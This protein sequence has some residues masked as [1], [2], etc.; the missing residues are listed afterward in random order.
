MTWR[1]GEA[2]RRAG[3]TPHA[4]RHYEALG[5]LRPRRSPSGQR[6]Y[7]EEDLKRVGFV[8]RAAALGFSLGEIAEIL[9]LRDGGEAPCSWV[10]AR[11]SEKV[12]AIEARI[13]ELARLRAELLELRDGPAVEGAP[14]AYCPVLEPPEVTRIVAQSGH[15]GL[16]RKA[17]RGRG[18]P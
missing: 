3:V 18:A 16:Q 1:I 17:G 7:G 15:R 9:R 4:L 5:L 13:A 12:A 6:L 14:A 2:S 8:R 10:R 11:L